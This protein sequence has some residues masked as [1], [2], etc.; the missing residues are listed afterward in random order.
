MAEQSIVCPQCGTEFPLS[1]AITKQIRQEVQDDFQEKIEA[2]RK[3]AERKAQ[4]A[5]AVELADLREQLTEKDDALKHLQQQELD[6][7]KREREMQ[8]GRAHV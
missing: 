6:L 5:A 8:I 2:E 7:R 3:R 1:E 4:D